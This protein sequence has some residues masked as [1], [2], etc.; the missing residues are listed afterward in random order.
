MLG[1][2]S[3]CVCYGW[4][5]VGVM[6]MWY[7]APVDEGPGLPQ[8][9]PTLDDGKGQVCSGAADLLRGEYQGSVLHD[10]LRK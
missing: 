7:D 4:V 1:Y 8:W 5:D 10:V 3:V 9:D 6:G 2:A